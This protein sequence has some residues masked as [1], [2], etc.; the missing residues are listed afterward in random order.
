MGKTV[1]EV[2]DLIHRIGQD[3][4]PTV[5]PALGF[6]PLIGILRHRIFTDGEGVTTLVGFHQCTLNCKYC[7]N[8]QSL[9]A[10]GIWKWCTPES[11]YKEVRKDN[12]YFGYTNGG[13]CFG[14]GEPLLRSKFIS[15][16][17]AVCNSEWHI[18]VETSLNI[19]L[20]NLVECY[21]AIDRF[22]VDIKDM[23]DE[24]YR[25][26]TGKS[27]IR[28]IENLK[29]LVRKGLA[30]KVLVRVPSISGFNNEND[31][32][33]SIQILN[34]MGF[35][36]IEQLVY[37]TGNG[38]NISSDNAEN[39]ELGKEIC[40]YL[41]NIRTKVA[42]AHNIS[43]TPAICTHKGACLGTCPVCEQEVEYIESQIHE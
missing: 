43:Y 24:I 7:L 26:Y 12:L 31:I 40:R 35:T 6:T 36:N 16:F 15:E 9:K 17:K 23:N 30:D 34:E 28:V 22:I 14:G 18:T 11:L 3:K 39:P 4:I 25:L 38:D 37:V 20:E 42:V 8:P 29:F 33:N 10:E 1:S 21:S 2:M 41:K 19:P 13:I 27:N 5:M 32:A